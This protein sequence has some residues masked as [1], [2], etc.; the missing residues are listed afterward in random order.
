MISSVYKALLVAIEDY[1]TDNRGDIGSWVREATINAFV[2]LSSLIVEFDAQTLPQ[3]GE[4]EAWFTPE[5][6]E[7]V[8]QRLIKQANERIDKM[9]D[10]AG[11]AFDTLLTKTNPM[12]PH[13]P[14]RSE[15]IELR[16]KYV[17]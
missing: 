4:E 12:V 17:W 6:S 7:L 3:Q 9:R 2:K 14:R 5:L 13:V 8:F 15:L 1:S 10:I 11:I 16:S